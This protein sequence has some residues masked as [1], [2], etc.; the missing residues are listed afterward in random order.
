MN[1]INYSHNA[2]NFANQLHNTIMNDTRLPSNCT[3]MPLN[4]YESIMLEIN[5]PNSNHI[6]YVMIMLP[7]NEYSG[8]FVDIMCS[9]SCYGHY[10]IEITIDT[11]EE[12]FSIISL[13]QNILPYQ[14]DVENLDYVRIPNNL[15]NNIHLPHQLQNLNVN[16]E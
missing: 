11:I 2:I 9:M 10:F 16:L 13:C 5:H 1:S 12:M 3:L 4:G 6:A 14:P 7:Y 8:G 15:L